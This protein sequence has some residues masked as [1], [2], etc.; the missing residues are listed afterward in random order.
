MQDI[1]STK[2]LIFSNTW[3]DLQCEKT[4]NHSGHYM[5]QVLKDNN[6]LTIDDSKSLKYSA[7]EKI[8]LCTMFIFK[9]NDEN[10]PDM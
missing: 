5:C 10:D 4:H 9:R 6:F 8:E 2:N 7:I 1:F 3:C